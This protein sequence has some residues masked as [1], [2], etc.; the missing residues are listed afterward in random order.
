MICFLCVTEK[1]QVAVSGD[2][3]LRV[4]V[5]DGQ[6]EYDPAEPTEDTEAAAHQAVGPILLVNSEKVV[7]V[8]YLT[9][10]IVY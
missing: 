2:E 6:E 7:R 4:S 8:I 1:R 9:T 10:C 3:S 5:G